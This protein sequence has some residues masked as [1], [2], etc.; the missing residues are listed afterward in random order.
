MLDM[1]N[2]QQQ[3]LLNE[4]SKGQWSKVSHLTKDECKKRQEL[5]LQYQKE[6]NDTHDFK[7]VWNKMYPLIHDAV[8]SN[9]LKLNKHN[10]VKNFDEKV[11]EAELLLIQRYK[12]KPDYNFRSLVT[13]CYWAAVWACRQENV[14]MGD[15]EDSWERL[16][17][18]QLRE[19][20][21]N[22]TF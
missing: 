18:L 7:I 12:N 20:H 6:Y 9:V 8:M 4:L 17:E 19:E 1:E 16:Q 2:Q 14:I 15:Q 11:S 5:F 22:D 13:L 21:I 3:E 10:F